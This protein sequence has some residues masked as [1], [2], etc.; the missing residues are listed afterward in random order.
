M[1]KFRIKSWGLRK[2]L[3]KTLVKNSLE[4]L[5]GSIPV[6][7]DDPA[8]LLTQVQKLARYL[9]RNRKTLRQLQE[10][11]GAAVQMLL[12]GA[13]D[14]ERATLGGLRRLQP[15][16]LR[17]PTQ[18]ELPDEIFRLLRTFLVSTS[19]KSVIRKPRPPEQDESSKYYSVNTHAL[20]CSAEVN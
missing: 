13:P 8:P 18:V 20:L 11:H 16:K 10:T 9:K 19:E 4:R 1:Y 2:N 3:A 5:E 7:G 6:G 14:S 17:A 12:T 15:S